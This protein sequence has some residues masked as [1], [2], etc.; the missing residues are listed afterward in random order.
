MKIT[1][2]IPAAILF[3]FIVLSNINA[4]SKWYVNTSLQ[5]TGSTF[6]DGSNHNSFFLYGGLTY[7]A[8]K[9]YLSLSLP[10]VITQSNTFT[11]IGN[12][13]LPNNHMGDNGSNNFFNRFGHMN[14]QNGNTMTNTN[15]GLGDLYLNSSFQV[16]DENKI[17]PSFSID[18]YIKF[19]TASSEIGIGTGKF[20]FQIA[21]GTKKYINNFSLFAQ[22]GYLFLGE[23]E[24]SEVLDPFTFTFGIGYT[25]ANRKHSFLFGYD[26]YSTI[27]QGAASPKQLALGYNYLINDGLYV[28]AIAAAGLNSSTSDY[29]FSVGLNFEI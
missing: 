8:Q 6:T 15:I 26:S 27:I 13:F 3:I 21:V 17:L 25:F 10:V 18:G 2:T 23:V 29:T 12:T 20:D 11:Q 22:F 1:S 9:L 5:T 19:P 7:Q 16:I 24:G 28:S 4:Q 14:N